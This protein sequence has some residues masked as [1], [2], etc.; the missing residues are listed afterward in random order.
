MLQ[1]LRIVHRRKPATFLADHG[2]LVWATCLRSLK[3]GGTPDAGDEFYTQQDAYRFLL[4]VIC[5]LK[6][7]IVGETEVFGQ[8]KIFSQEWV[9]REPKRATLIQKLLS[10]AKAIRSRHLTGLGVQSYGS[11]VRG[12]LT[13]NRVH[14]LGAGQLAREIH[15]YL[16]KQ[17]RDLAIHVREP[18]RVGDFASSKV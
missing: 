14:F 15:P 6:S 5:G 7:P 11:W 18:L 9:K 16:A 3:F 12:K 2:P 17:Q 13:H 4:E 1:D 10:D 8:F